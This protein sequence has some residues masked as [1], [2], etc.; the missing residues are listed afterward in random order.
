[1]TYLCGF[2]ADRGVFIR[3]EASRQVHGANGFA[4]DFELEQIYRGM[5]CL[6]IV[7]VF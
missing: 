6:E 4:K 2:L 1:M 3:K 7:E 5:K